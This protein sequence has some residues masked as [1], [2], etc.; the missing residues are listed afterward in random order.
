MDEHT[1]MRHAAEAAST[2]PTRKGEPDTEI[3]DSVP[4][5]DELPFARP[6]LH[7][8][9][10][11]LPPIVESM[12][13]RPMVASGSAKLRGLAASANERIRLARARA[14]ADADAN[15]PK[16]GSE[17]GRGTD[18]ESRLHNL[19]GRSSR[20]ISAE[21]ARFRYELGETWNDLERVGRRWRRRRRGVQIGQEAL[22]RYRDLG[23][24][25]REALELN[26]LARAYRER[27]DFH[28]A[29]VCY[30]QALSIFERLGNQRGACLSLSNLGLTHDAQGNRHKAVRCYEQALDI[31]RSLR[32]RQIEGQILANLGTAYNRQGRNREARDLWGQALSLLT[33]GSS[34]HRQL[35]QHLG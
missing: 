32:D 5:G 34:A 33:P 24:H 17:P 10:I 22:A 12:R 20:R 28:E 14:Q 8:S 15:Q 11:R 18:D 29:T 16:G 3:P 6:Q 7:K 2:D 27:A 1:E 23:D 4:R 30:T 13:A 19:V 25:R 35:S 26:T 31:A 21:L 9:A